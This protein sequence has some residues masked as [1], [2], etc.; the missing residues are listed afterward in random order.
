MNKQEA[1][2]NCIEYLQEHR[3]Y[4]DFEMTYALGDSDA[5]D[6]ICSHFSTKDGS[7][8]END[9]YLVVKDILEEAN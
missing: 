6:Y 3:Y 7:E 8:V 2:Y 5:A 9:V 1:I 4:G